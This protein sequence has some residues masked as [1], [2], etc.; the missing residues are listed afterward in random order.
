M[1][2]LSPILK[3]TIEAGKIES[4]EVYVLANERVGLLMDIDF[5]IGSETHQEIEQL[6]KMITDYQKIHYQINMKT[7][8]INISKGPDDF[9][10]YAQDLPFIY[11]SG[12]TIEKVKENVL[13]AIALYKEHNTE[14]PEILKGEFEI[15]YNELSPNLT[16]FDDMQDE[17][18]GKKGTP[19]REASEAEYEAF[20]LENKHE[21]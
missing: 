3:A 8:K 11:A 7:L 18:Y 16:L 9:G 17:L 20:K 14:L 19:E 10:A 5:E 15:E 6:V 12:E 21:K 4:V 13:E 2:E 1:E